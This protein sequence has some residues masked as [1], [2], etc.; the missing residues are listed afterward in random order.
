MELNSLLPWIQ[1]SLG[2]LQSNAKLALLREL[3]S[4][5]PLNVACL[6]H[7]GELFP[8][9]VQL[10]IRP[11]F[12]FSGASE[13]LESNAEAGILRWT[14]RDRWAKKCGRMSGHQRLKGII[15]SD[16]INYQMVISHK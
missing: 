9:T 7:S 2:S 1:N 13:Q 14:R 8:V 16:Q 11:N 3:Y 4:V 15:R 5:A 12:N 10:I 6:Q